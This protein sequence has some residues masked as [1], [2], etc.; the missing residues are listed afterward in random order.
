MSIFNWKK[1]KPEDDYQLTNE[2]WLLLSNMLYKNINRGQAINSFINKTDYIEKG[3]VRNAAVYSV[4]STRANAAKGIPWLVYKVKSGSKL[5]QYKGISNKAADL[6]RTLTLKASALEEVSDTVVNRLLEKPNPCQSFSEIIESMFV[7]RDTTGD[8]YL[9]QVANPWTKEI[10]QLF[11]L[12]SDKTKIIAGPFNNPI[13]G[14]SFDDFSKEL[15]L[16]ENVFHWKYFNPQWDADGRQLYGLS[17]LVAA[18]QNIN[19]DNA[20]ID[21]E[22]SSF[23]NEGVKGILTGTKDTEIEF[24]KAQSDLLQKKLS[25][26]TRRAKEGGGSVAFNRAPMDYIKIG[27]TPVDLGVLD[28]RKYNKEVLCNIFQIHPSLLSSDAST[29][30]NLS[31]ARKA[32]LTMS[33]MP[34]MDSLRDNLNTMIQR[35]FGEQWFVDYDIMAISELQDDLEKL[36]KTLYNMDWISAN[37]KRAAT[38]YEEYDKSTT[39]PADMIF[40]D[41]GKVPLGYG[42]DSGFDDIDDNIDKIRI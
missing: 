12:P 27:E 20:G 16:P 32:L 4:I 34:D 22:T 9:A 35:S 1:I 29:L 28:S 38:Q 7:Y 5:K 42:M 11:V 23:A 8:A 33:V 6:H 13:A 41:M 37:E 10:I 2:D 26:A 30:N 18:S 19:S 3:Y 39:N 15:I 36:S 21:N 25:K 17:P 14:Y 31:E 40:T 24:T